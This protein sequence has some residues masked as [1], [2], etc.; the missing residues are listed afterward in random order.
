MLNKIR[1]LREKKGFT[2]V[3]LIVVIAV[4]VIA[5]IAILTAVFVFPARKLAQQRDYTTLQDG[6][7]TIS[8]SVNNAMAKVTMGGAPSSIVQISVTKDD[9][10]LTIEVD[11]EQLIV[12]G[13]NQSAE[14]VEKD[15]AKEVSNALSATL[16][17][18][19]AFL[20]SITGGAVDGVIYRNDIETAIAAGAVSKA[21]G[22]FNDAYE[23]TVGS[24]KYAVGVSGKFKGEVTVTI[25]DKKVVEA[26]LTEKKDS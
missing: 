22:D 12:E 25:T 18:G 7:L 13:E 21:P 23:Y 16:P 4:I 1:K 17:N 24:D 2:L 19:S 14:S 10:T 6:A 3:A 8:N 5:I 11:G 20:A 15:I 26:K 9:N